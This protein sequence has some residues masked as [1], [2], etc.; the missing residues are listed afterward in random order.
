MATRVADPRPLVDSLVCY[1]NAAI[2]ITVT[3]KGGPLFLRGRKVAS[4]RRRLAVSRGSEHAPLPWRP[5]DQSCG[6]TQCNAC[7]LQRI[8]THMLMMQQMFSLVLLVSMT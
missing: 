5:T 7:D 2:K 3:M 4:R 8:F 1:D 6:G